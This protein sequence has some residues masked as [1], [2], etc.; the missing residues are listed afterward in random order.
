MFHVVDTQKHSEQ[1]VASL[2]Q[3]YL[4]VDWDPH[5]DLAIL[6]GWM[7]RKHKNVLNAGCSRSHVGGCEV[8]D[9]MTVL[10]VTGCSVLQT[11]S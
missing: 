1:E 7:T 3:R 6:H 5:C 10:V 4:Q 8:C 11:G 2:H 9:H